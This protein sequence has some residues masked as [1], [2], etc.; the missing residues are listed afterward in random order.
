MYPTKCDH[1]LHAVYSTINPEWYTPG[2]FQALIWALVAMA[3]DS[4]K[5][6]AYIPKELS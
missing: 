4:Y 1:C 6:T 5:P 2:H 3:R